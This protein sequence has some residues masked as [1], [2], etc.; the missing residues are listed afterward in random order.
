MQVQSPIKGGGRDI[1]HTRFGSGQ[2]GIEI[3][4]ARLFAIQKSLVRG[5]MILIK[6]QGSILPLTLYKMLGNQYSCSPCFCLYSN[7]YA[8]P[9]LLKPMSHGHWMVSSDRRSLM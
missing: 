9:K 3:R 2:T 5:G 1:M 7:I 4:L 6:P 8:T